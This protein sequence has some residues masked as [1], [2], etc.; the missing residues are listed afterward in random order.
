[1]INFPSLLAI[2]SIAMPTLHKYVVMQIEHVM[3]G[4][5][6]HL[7]LPNGTKMCSLGAQCLQP[8]GVHRR[9]VKPSSQET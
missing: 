2:T 9:K 7:V 8:Q 1:M 4:Y 5:Y 3:L 6:F